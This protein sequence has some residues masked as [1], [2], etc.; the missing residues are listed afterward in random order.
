M[1]N[2]FAAQLYT[3]REELKRGIDPVFKELKEMGWNAVQLSALPAGYDPEEVARALKE[4]QLKAAGIHISIDRLANDLDNVLEE[5]S[6]YET[7]DIVCPYLPDQYR[8]V[9]GYEKVKTLLNE[10]A[11]K[12]PGYRISYHNHDFEFK[13]EINEKSALEYLLEPASDNKIL[14]EIDVFWVKKGGKDPVQFL[15]P[16][17]NRMPIIHLKDMTNDDQQTFAAVGTGVIDFAPILDWCEKSG[18]EWY[19]VEQDVCPGNPMD[20]L[21]TSLENLNQLASQ[22]Q[23]K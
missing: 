6:L 13:T 7:K 2:K 1:R 16:Y 22:F 18:V 5:V 17:A 20:S 15:Q 19:A 23:S 8:T 21:R 9:E 10:V 3:V 14:A 4:N 12:A 11:K